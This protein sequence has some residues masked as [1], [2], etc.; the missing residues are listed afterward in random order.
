MTIHRKVTLQL[1][2]DVCNQVF[3][4]SGSNTSTNIKV[5]RSTAHAFGWRCQYIKSLDTA[6]DLC[7]DCASYKEL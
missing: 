3:E 1:R 5:L 2:C 6:G 4:S 7:R